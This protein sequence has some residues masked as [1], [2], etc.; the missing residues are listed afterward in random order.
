M[1][2]IALKMLIGDR[3]KYAGLLFGITFTSFLVAFALSF[4]AGF[5][6]RGFSL[7]S[8]NFADI[9]VMS[10][11]V[12]SAAQTSNMS[13]SALARVRSVAGVDSASPLAL[14]TANVIFPNGRVQPFQVIGV[15]NVTLT[16]IPPLKDGLQSTVLRA[17][18][19]VII[20]QGGTSGKLGYPLFTKDQW[21]YGTPHLEAPTR[22]IHAGDDLLVND[23]HVKVAGIGQALPRFPPR[24]LLYTSY[25]NANNILLSGRRQLTFILVNAAAGISPRHLAERISAQTGLRARSKADFKADTVRWFFIN[26]EDVGD[27][28]AMLYLAL[29]VG[30]GVTGVMLYMFTYENI[31]QYAVLKAMGATPKLLTTMILAQA[32]LCAIIGTGMGLGLCTIV[33]ELLS[34]KVG[35]PF[36]MMWFT[37]IFSGFAVLV[38]SLVAALISARP[39]LKLDPATVFAGR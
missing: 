5:M 21:P 1:R 25:A 26:S 16:G 32:G 37:P 13:S 8:E 34:S 20:D 2:R 18:H 22:Q 29:S 10:P 38:I 15:D 17:P 33:G 11:A 19:T 31:G 14:G 27:M 7:V 30:F 3:V 28:M 4:F 24:P 12:S 39:V 9:W 6:T 23:Y 36:R 35:Y